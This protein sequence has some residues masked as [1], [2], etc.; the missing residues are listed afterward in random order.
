MK[1]LVAGGRGFIGRAVCDALSRA[2]HQAVVLSRRPGGG[3]MAWDPA[4]PG[5]WR[6]EAA[7]A[8]AVINLCGESVADGRW[9]QGRKRT[10]RES[11]MIPTRALAEAVRASPRKPAFVTASA[12]GC[13]GNRGDE[14]LDESSPPRP[15]SDFLAALCLDWETAAL[16]AAGNGASTA[17]LRIGVALHPEGGALAKMLPPFKLFAGGPLGNGR[18]WMS[19]ITRTD[20][21]RMIVTAVEDRWNGIFNATAPDPA[22]NVEFSRNLGAALGRP[23]WLPAPAPALRLV[24]GEMAG[25]LL[26]GQ[27]VLPKAA[28]AK[29]FEFRHPDLKSALRSCLEGS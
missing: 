20:L 14:V 25:M 7:G 1:V 2:G 4:L 24:L 13:Y 3:S 23:C 15:E 27:R 10:L 29:D 8:D 22:R 12:V 9:T 19:W 26:G 18:Q 5:P 28:L 6:E 11:R 16:P 17:I 21:A